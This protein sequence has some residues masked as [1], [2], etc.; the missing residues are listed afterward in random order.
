MSINKAIVLARKGT[1]QSKMAVAT[2]ALWLL[3]VQDAEWRLA[4]GCFPGM[5]LK[6]IIVEAR[7]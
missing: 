1:D 6:Q 5:T 3:G 7:K 4:L 2:R